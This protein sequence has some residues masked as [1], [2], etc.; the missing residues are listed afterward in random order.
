MNADLIVLCLAAFA[1]VALLVS[2]TVALALPRL[3]RM[4]ERF[5]ASQRAR[6][7]LGLATLPTVVAAI[8]VMVSLLPA[9]GFGEDHCLAH[10]PHHPHLCPNHLGDTPG[11][12][13]LVFALVV[14]V[15]VFGA[16]W[17]VA[18]AL[19][20]NVKTARSLAPG[21]E[22]R[23][24]ACVF[25]A[26][27]PQA[28]TLGIL[29]PR[30]YVSRSLLDDH[31]DVAEPALAHERAH[32]ARKD[33]LWRAVCPLLSA[34]H[35]PA[36][37]T[38]LNARFRAAQEM[39]ADDDAAE[40]LSNGR[41]RVAEAILT[42]VRRMRTEPPGLSLTHGDVEARVRA[43][44]E[45]RLSHRAWPVRL[46]LCATLALVALGA[47]AHESVHHALELLLGAFG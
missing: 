44:L 3:D 26:Q 42:L 43:L 37:A 19:W 14:T 7:W 20:L 28:F 41:V 21:C 29:R 18:R 46:S 6:L 23:D 38:A 34:A 5:P 40:T 35:L 10:G 9:V 22:E 4:A 33:P 1:L 32:A 13:L 30:V 47:F 25:D 2:S 24:G 39:A 27:E 36:I 12:V 16:A 17:G 11:I 31:G 45:P 8:A 15:R